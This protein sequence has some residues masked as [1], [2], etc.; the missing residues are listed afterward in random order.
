MVNTLTYTII[1]III[2][3]AIIT[4][5]II[6]FTIG[7]ISAALFVIIAILVLTIT[8]TNI[9]LESNQNGYMSCPLGEYSITDS[10]GNTNSRFTLQ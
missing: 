5:T 1:I 2:P 3:Y 6:T 4:D 9:W 7:T 8:S 10:N